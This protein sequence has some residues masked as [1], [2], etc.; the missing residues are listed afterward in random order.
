MEDF[1]LL[2]YEIEKN[3]TSRGKKKEDKIVLMR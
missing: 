3:E 1:F 2:Q